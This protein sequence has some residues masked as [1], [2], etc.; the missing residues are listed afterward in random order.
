MP[1]FATAITNPSYT[2]LEVDWPDTTRYYSKVGVNSASVG[3]YQPRVKSF[4][5]IRYAL[6]D[7]SK[8]L[9]YVTMTITLT[10]GDETLLNMLGKGYRWQ[11]SAVRVY[12][13]PAAASGKSQ[14]TSF[15]V[16]VLDDFQPAGRGLWTLTVAPK[17]R[18]LRAP[19]PLTQ[20]D[21]DFA[22]TADKTALGNQ[23][24]VLAGKHDD[25]GDQNTGAVPTLYVDKTNFYFLVCIGWVTVLRVYLAAALKTLTTHY[26]V[27]HS[28]IGGRLYTI[29]KMVGDPGT[30]AVTCD[31]EGPETVGNGTGAMITEAT[32]VLKWL[33]ANFVYAEYQSGNWASGAGNAPL[34][35]T[36]FTTVQSALSGRAGGAAFA[37]ARYM[38]SQVTGE[39]FVNEWASSM[40]VDVAWD[41]NGNLAL[42]YDDCYS[43]DPGYSLSILRFPGDLGEPHVAFD[44]RGAVSTGVIQY[45]S[46]ASE[47]STTSPQGFS[48]K[49]KKHKP[50]PTNRDGRGYYKLQVN[51]PL[52]TIP[53][54]LNINAECGPK[55]TP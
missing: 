12:V 18:Q 13:A 4:G 28:I 37:A 15:F 24:P 33:L 25:Y 1:T 36:S 14:W 2:L 16:G 20:T 3:A 52:S 23:I 47:P 55:T 19:F 53:A 46:F 21:E 10:D 35:T 8:S 27:L 44:S 45:E 31:I 49:L 9:Q 29:I 41:Q 54:S 6:G 26:T 34:N 39:N 22:T 40:G 48:S 17:V 42:Y 30:S 7:E 5:T 50:D 11:Y 43:N 51:D 38:S 32:D